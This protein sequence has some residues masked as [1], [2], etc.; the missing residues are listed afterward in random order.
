MSKINL[1]IKRD[2]AG[3]I[4]DNGPEYPSLYLS[5]VDL[6]LSKSN[7]GQSLKAVVTLKFTGYREDNSVKRNYKSYDFAIQDVEFSGKGIAE[8]NAGDK[9]SKVFGSK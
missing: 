9:L 2:K 4:P 3:K 8:K 5:D 1:K 6:P 7:I